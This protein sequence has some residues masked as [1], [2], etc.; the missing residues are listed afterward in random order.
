LLGAA[1]TMR[2]CFDEGSLDAPVARDS[3]RAALGQAGFDAR[4]EHGRGLDRD[5]AITL[6][7][8]AVAITVDAA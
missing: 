8:G 3:A 2:G 6:A 7:A 4:Y 5:D 1:H